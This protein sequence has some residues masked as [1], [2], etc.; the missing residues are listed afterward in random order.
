MTTYGNL[1]IENKATNQPPELIGPLIMHQH[2]NWKTYSRF[3]N[4]LIEEKMELGALLAGVTNGEKALIDGFQRNFRF[5]TFLRWF[6][7]FK[8]NKKTELK[9]RNMIS[10]QQAL[11]AANVWKARRYNQILWSCRQRIHPRVRSEVRE[12]EK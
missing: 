8:G 4:S 3:V 10:T 2:K 1:K 7:H 6:I 12:S 9:N 5:A 11:H